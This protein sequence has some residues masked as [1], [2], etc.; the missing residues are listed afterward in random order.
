MLDI[1]GIKDKVFWAEL[2]FE[3]FAA[4]MPKGKRYSSLPK[5]PP[6]ERDLAVVVDMTLLSGLIGDKIKEAGGDLV[7]RIT[8]FDVYKGKQVPAGKRSLA[9]SICYRSPEKTLTDEE[10]DEIHRRVISELEKT[11]GAT[12]RS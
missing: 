6:V 11:F 1:W 5:F 10:V 4:R 12:L 2:D 8:L 3:I 9:Y 7:E